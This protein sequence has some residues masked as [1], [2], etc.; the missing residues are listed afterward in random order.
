M[1]IRPFF[2]EYFEGISGKLYLKQR[3][4]PFTVTQVETNRDQIFSAYSPN[5]RMSEIQIDNYRQRLG[6]ANKI[7]QM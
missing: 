6:E 5:V 2:R 3:E 7:N 1:K 4:F